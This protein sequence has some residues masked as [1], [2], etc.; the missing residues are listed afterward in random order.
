M[1]AGT[2]YGIGVGPG[3]SDLVTIRGATIMRGCRRIFVP[4]A[5]TNSESVARKIAEEFLGENA[6]VCELV[7][8]M[9][10]DQAALTS[11]WSKSAAQV[12]EALQQGQDVCF[13]SLGD[14]MLYST[15][16]YLLRALRAIMPN[17]KVITVPGIT[18]FSLA[19]ALTEFHIGEG[20][21]TVTIVP[22]S[23]NLETA[24]RALLGGG[25]IV[26]M[27]IGKHLRELLGILEETGMIDRAVFVA[28]AGMDN[29]RI[30]T[31]L[32]VLGSESEEIGYLSII[33]AHSGRE[34]AK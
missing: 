31:N 16:I 30:E 13:L 7:F 18:S 26:M 2:F 1:N 32:R 17:V 21:E 11:A 4:K 23:G 3:A 8:P 19:A 5:R 22:V 34:S 9:T 6:E 24:R 20:R 28:H 14:V 10:S 15:Y 33:I 29:Q 27:K 12:A 25:T